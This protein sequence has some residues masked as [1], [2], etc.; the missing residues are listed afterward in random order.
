MLQNFN[1]YKHLNSSSGKLSFSSYVI[2]VANKQ[3]NIYLYIYFDFICLQMRRFD[4]KIF[5]NKTLNNS[6]KFNVEKNMNNC[7]IFMSY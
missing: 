5:Q 1:N 6:L 4:V 7:I 3:I 2:V